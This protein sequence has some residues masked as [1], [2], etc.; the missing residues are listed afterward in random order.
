MRT[1]LDALEAVVHG[2]TEGPFTVSDVGEDGRFG[3]RWSIE[4]P[5]Q[6]PTSQ[7][8]K[9]Y[10]HCTVLVQSGGRED[11]EAVAA[12]MTA[13]PA[14]ITELR[15]SR[16][17]VD[18]VAEME[19]IGSDSSMAYFCPMHCGA[20]TED[21]PVHSFSEGFVSES[22]P[23]TEE[24][25]IYDARQTAWREKAFFEMKHAPSCAWVMARAIRQGSVTP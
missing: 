14:L 25:D 1:D 19:P 15:A 3:P 2:A 12:G 8:Y 13:L 22:D 17:V 5:V 10:T 6:R 24:L 4:G 11:A 7:P 16:A 20:Q 21:E 9:P 23:T 18:A